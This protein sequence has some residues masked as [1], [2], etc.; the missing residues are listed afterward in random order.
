[1]IPEH[2]WQRVFAESEARR[3]CDEH[4]IDDY[5]RVLA[6][7]LHRN[8]LEAIDP[9]VRMKVR[10]MSLCISPCVMLVRPDGSLEMLPRELPA[11]VSDFVAQIDEMIAREA[12]R[13]GVGRPR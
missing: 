11:A 1:M 5:P 13:W 12:E 10:A 4:G 7:V 6:Y 9:Y 2:N 8:F 3:L